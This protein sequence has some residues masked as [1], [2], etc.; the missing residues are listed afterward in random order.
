MN[1][2]KISKRSQLT[3]LCTYSLVSLL[4][5]LEYL[6]I[7]E[8]SSDS[9]CDKFYLL[10]CRILSGDV[11]KQ[12]IS[13]LLLIMVSCCKMCQKWLLAIFSFPEWLMMMTEG[14]N[15]FTWGNMIYFIRN[16]M[17]LDWQN[18]TFKV[19]LR[20]KCNELIGNMSRRLYSC[21]YSYSSFSFLNS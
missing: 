16:R 9:S 21:L 20:F 15:Y 17:K 6:F 7:N 8:D 19:G 12:S 18:S 5:L 3:S 11:L 10:R 13:R 14:L 4:N 1:L 2:A